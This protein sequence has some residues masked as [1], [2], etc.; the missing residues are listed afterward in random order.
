MRCEPH[1][2]T[3]TVK[4]RSPLLYTRARFLTLGCS[5]NKLDHQM[6]EALDTHPIT[7]RRP[8]VTP[9]SGTRRSNQSRHW[10][11]RRS[12]APPCLHVPEPTSPRRDDGGPM[13]GGHQSRIPSPPF[14]NSSQLH[15]AH[16]ITKTR[17]GWLLVIDA[18]VTPAAT[19][20]G[21]RR[22]NEVRW[23]I[24]AASSTSS[25][26]YAHGQL[27]ELPPTTLDALPRPN[28]PAGRI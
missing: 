12:R 27:R 4:I 13:T 10:P 24:Q 23:A 21:Q 11:D 25:P 22:R 26:W 19:W 14:S 18:S 17:M 28:F 3:S 16:C 2:P 8:R 9:R 15:N 7:I 6:T 5:I 20:G 1:D